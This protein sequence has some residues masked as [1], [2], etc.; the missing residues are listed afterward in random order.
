MDVASPLTARSA[1]QSNPD[2]TEGTLFTLARKFIALATIP[3]GKAWHPWMAASDPD[4]YHPSNP[5]ATG[6]GQP[7]P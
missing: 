6:D 2:I 7:A 4:S 3:V 1:D 5:S